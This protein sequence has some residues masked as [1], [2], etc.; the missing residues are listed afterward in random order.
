M[1]KTFIGS[2][3]WNRCPKCRTGSL[4]VNKSSFRVTRFTD[5]NDNCP[6]CGEDLQREPGFYFGASYVSYALTVAIWVAVYVAL[7]TFDTIG[8]ISYNF[9]DNPWTFLITGVVI[10]L[11]LLPAIFRLSRSIWISMFVRFKKS[12]T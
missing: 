12:E 9:F 1:K 3:I 11:V 4:F 8:F 10:L 6:H 2:V 5:F 7:I